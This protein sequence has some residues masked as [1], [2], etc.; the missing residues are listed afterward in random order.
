M[1]CEVIG[2]CPGCRDAEINSR[3]VDIYVDRNEK[4]ELLGIY[5]FGDD[6]FDVVS[7]DQSITEIKVSDDGK[8]ITE[9]TCPRCLERVAVNIPVIKTPE[10]TQ[11]NETKRV[12]TCEGVEA[13]AI[14]Q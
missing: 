10:K 1:K 5:I 4:G 2:I 12:L 9:I 7:K 14:E 6:D 3:N 11:V 8:T 13:K